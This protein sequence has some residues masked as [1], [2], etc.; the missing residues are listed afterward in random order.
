MITLK[1]FFSI[2]SLTEAF[3][4]VVPKNAVIFVEDDGVFWKINTKGLATDSVS[5]ILSKTQINDP[6][7]ANT[8]TDFKESVLGLRT[9]AAM[10]GSPAQG[11]RYLCTATSGAFTADTIYQ[12]KGTSWLADPSNDGAIVFSEED[13]YFY[14]K[15]SVGVFTAWAAFMDKIPKDQTIIASDGQTVF[16]TTIT[17]QGLVEIFLDGIGTRDFV[18][19]NPKQ[20]TLAFGVDDGTEV[21]IKASK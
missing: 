19:D 2:S 15:N 1:P 21:F 18:I 3:G 8:L 4:R 7:G 6:V 17:L 16:A 12:Y 11:D 10:P 9:G 13:S 5:T 14:I 20:F